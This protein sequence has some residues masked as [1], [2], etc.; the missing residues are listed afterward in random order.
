MPGSQGAPISHPRRGAGMS[1]KAS[2]A[3]I[4]GFVVGALILVVAGIIVFGSGKFFADIVQAV[5]Y[6]EV[7]NKR[8]RVCAWMDCKGSHIV[9]VSNIKTVFDPKETRVY[10]PVIVEIARDKIQWVGER[11]TKGSLLPQ[12]VERRIRGQLQSESMVTG[13]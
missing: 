5:M 3:V 11:P 8:L 9:T 12:L 4:G 1:Q 6:F 10:I 2:P 7:E 13:Q